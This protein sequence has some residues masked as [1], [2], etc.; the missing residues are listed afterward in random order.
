M[1]LCV[2]VYVRVR[3]VLSAVLCV[4]VCVCVCVSVDDVCMWV[5][6]TKMERRNWTLKVALRATLIVFAPGAPAPPPPP[7]LPP[8]LARSYTA[9][10]LLPL[11]LSFS[12]LCVCLPLSSATFATFSQAG[13]IK[14]RKYWYNQLS[15]DL[16]LAKFE[17]EFDF[18]ANAPEDGAP[19]QK[20]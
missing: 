7:L 13:A 14:V 18:R 19:Q 9:L 10:F 8:P 16:L 20:V 11:P 12:F 1:Y 17:K 6:P 3:A 15:T 5:C 2:Y 4:R